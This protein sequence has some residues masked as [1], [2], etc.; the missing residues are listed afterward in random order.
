[1]RRFTSYGPIDIEEHYYAPRKNLIEHAYSQ[2]LGENPKKGGHYITVWAP[3]QCGKTWVMQEVVEKIKKNREYEVGIISMQR[4]KKEQN[5]QKVLEIFIKKLNQAFEKSLPL[6]QKISDIP[7]L[8]TKQYF[9]KPVILILDEFDALIEDFINDFANIFRDIFISRTNERGKPTGD[10]TYLL[11]SL[12]LVGV[13]SVL[14]IENDTGSPFNI[15]RSVHIL[16][17]TFEEVDD[18]FAWY[19]RDSGQKVEKEVVGRLFDETQGQPGLTC[20]FGELLSEGVEGYK[21]DSHRPIDMRDFEIVYAAAT[22]ALPNNNILNIISKAKEKN[23]KPTI[24]EMFQTTGKLEFRFDNDIINALYMNGIADKEIEDQSRYYVRF[25]CPFV[26]KR[27]FNYFS[28]ELFGKIGPLTNPYINLDNVITDTELNIP[29]ILRLYETYLKTNQKWLFKSAPRRKNDM[30]IYEA[31]YHFNLFSYL[32][33]FLKEGGKVFPEFPTG[34][35]KIDLILAYGSNQYGVELKSFVNERNYKNALAKAA[36]YGKQLKLPE[37]YLVF[38]V[39]YIDE[40]H[41]KEYEVERVDEETGIKVVIVF[42]ET[43]NP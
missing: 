43:G 28:H 2:L 20:W 24:L 10:K 29:G 27:L 6:L 34:N 38:F 13:R 41:R 1:M 21:I 40:E 30:R 16:N 11:H 4:L 31:V 36:R 22:Y 33:A 3:R 7:D 37:I 14:G 35:G 15:Q 9:Q 19:E 5:E 32:K 25:S 8:F 42:I 17:L 23:N 12:A 26:Q 39:E 18:M